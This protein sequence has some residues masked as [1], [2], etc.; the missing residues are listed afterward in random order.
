MLIRRGLIW[1]RSERCSL[2]KMGEK[3]HLKQLI[4]VPSHEQSCLFFVALGQL[5]G[6][7]SSDRIHQM[8]AFDGICKEVE[9]IKFTFINQ[10]QLA[11][12]TTLTLGT[13]R[14]AKKK[15]LPFFKAPTEPCGESGQEH[16]VV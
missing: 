12:G 5:E 11:N 14:V 15:S 8:V 7:G 9:L 3:L 16:G 6:T 4:S 1:G 13:C 10:L 2:R